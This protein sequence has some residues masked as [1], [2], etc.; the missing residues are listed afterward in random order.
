MVQGLRFSQ[1]RED[2]ERLLRVEAAAL[3]FQN[4]ML[5][6]AKVYFAFSNVAF[7][8]REMRQDP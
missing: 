8:Q 3:Q 1:C 4:Q 2:L 7:G 5:L 6:P